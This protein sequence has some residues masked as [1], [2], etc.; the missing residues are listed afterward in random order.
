MTT[1]NNIYE[2]RKNLHN[3]PEKSFEEL[4]TM[5]LLIEFIAKNTTFTIV[6]KDKWFYAYKKSTRPLKKPIALR[7]DMDGITLSDGDTGHYCGH[8]GHCAII[9]Y[10]AVLLSRM[11][12]YRDVYL[13]F[14]PAEEIGQ[15][16]KL[17]CQLLEEKE[18]SEVYGLHNI[19]GFPLGSILLRKKTFACGSTG[20]K[21]S[22]TGKPTHA[23]YPENGINPTDAF[24][25][26]INNIKKITSVYKENGRIL[27]AT[28]IGLN[29]G[30]EQF[31]M[32]AHSGN[33]NL[34]IRA[35]EQNIFVNYLSAIKNEARQLAKKYNLKCSIEE[36]DYFPVTENRENCVQKLEDICQKNA[37]EYIYLTEPMR[38]SED[39]G[40]YLQKTPGAFFGIGD[41]ENYAQLHT[42][43]YQFPD[44]IIEKAAK[45]FT[46]II[47]L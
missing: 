28:V 47:L 40:Y 45:M 16:A 31:G 41:G 29:L 27:L 18:I 26:L 12:V 20:L 38:W 42:K 14:Q 44:D 35:D 9:C 46:E 13:I 17:C 32:S 11:N 4:K 19:P 36:T 30:S 37:W 15:G 10:V 39:F 1:V 25:E 3:I 7:C 21:I 33:L 23:A 43:D 34:T 2:L 22:Y 8:D 6:K 5:N 24:V